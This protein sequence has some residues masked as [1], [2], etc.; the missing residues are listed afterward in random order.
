[1][2]RFLEQSQDLT[3]LLPIHQE[4]QQ[5]QDSLLRKQKL[6]LVAKA[7]DLILLPFYDAETVGLPAP[8]L[9]SEMLKDQLGSAN[10]GL[11]P[12]GLGVHSAPNNK[13]QSNGSGA[14]AS[15]LLSSM[16]GRH[17]NE[18]DVSLLAT[19]TVLEAISQHSYSSDL[20]IVLP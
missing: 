19:G 17:S 10:E 12:N 3:E 16:Q 8:E 15:A 1:M 9:Q 14:R 11:D 18:M 5:L 2:N 4:T 6:D 13:Q 20:P 7:R